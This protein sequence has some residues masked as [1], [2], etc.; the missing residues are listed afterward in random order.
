MVLIGQQL[1]LDTLEI[2]GLI[3]VFTVWFPFNIVILP[4]LNKILFIIFV[5]RLRVHLLKG[6]NLVFLRKQI[7]C[8]CFIFIFVH[9][10]GMW[11][12][13]QIRMAVN[14]LDFVPGQGGVNLPFPCIFRYFNISLKIITYS[15]MALPISVVF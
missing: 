6:T 10:K 7:V 15:H 1:W 8:G 9:I 2:N 13:Y 11:H 5:E 4:T 12:I 3:V 14:N